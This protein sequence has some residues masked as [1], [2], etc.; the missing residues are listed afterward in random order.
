MENLFKFSNLIKSGLICLLISLFFISCKD[1]KSFEPY[2]DVQDEVLVGSTGG[3]IVINFT[4]SHPWYA[5][6]SNTWIQLTRYRGQMSL[7]DSIIAVMAENTAMETRE[8]YIEV[9]L[10]DQMS[11][12]I[13][14]TQYGK[15]NSINLPKD[16]VYFN[17]NGGSTDISVLTDLDW[18]VEPKQQDGF[19]FEKKDNNTLNITAPQNSTGGE[20]RISVTI[21][22]KNS[23]ESKVLTVVQS[24]EEKMLNITLSDENKDILIQKGAQN[25]EIPIITN[26]DFELNTLGEWLNVEPVEYSGDGV[27]AEELS[28]NITITENTTGFER[29]GYVQIKDKNSDKSDMYQISQMARSR[30]IYVKPGGN[31]TGTSWEDAYGDIVAANNECGD[32][33][34]M[35]LW[36]AEGEYQLSATL[37]CRSVNVYGGF[38]GNE[39][40]LKDRDLSKKSTI[41]GGDFFLLRSEG[42]SDMQYIFDG[43]ILTGANTASEAEWGGVIRMTNRIFSNNIVHS[44]TFHRAACGYYDNCKVINCLFYNNTTTK[45]SGGIYLLNGSSVYNSTIVNNKVNSEWKD[46]YLVRAANNLKMYNT[47]IWGNTIDNDKNSQYHLADA[48]ACTLYNCAVVNLTSQSAYAPINS[49]CITDLNPDNNSGPLFVNPESRDYS[50]QSSSNLIDKGDNSIID[51]L[52]IMKDIVGGLRVSGGTVDLGAYEYQK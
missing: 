40:K 34:D 6:A 49:N 3:K 25:I 52:G 45:T 47:I 44:N 39:T 9:R 46:A 10:M 42:A 50:L 8:G 14:I 16:V 19:T 11:K 27:L 5:E 22:D 1:E 43:F 29:Y 13:K 35:E 23:N 38:T 7:P 17:I 12:R 37:A 26:V 51:E 2:I 18:D 15:G 4:S 48:N 28:L 20:R 32:N 33:G 31:G 21:K 41:K 30:R 24:N 36:V